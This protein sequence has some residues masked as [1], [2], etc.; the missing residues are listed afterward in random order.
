MNALKVW[1]HRTRSW[2]VRFDSFDTLRRVNTRV[3]R[4][5][6]ENIHSLHQVIFMDDF[7]GQ[8]VKQLKTIHKKLD[9]VTPNPSEGWNLG[10]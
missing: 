7:N 3:Y 2:N 9:L 5:L 8:C 4:D 1:E 6:G 10:T